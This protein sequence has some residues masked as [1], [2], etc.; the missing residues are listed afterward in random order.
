MPHQV[1]HISPAEDNTEYFPASPT[2]SHASSDALF[3]PAPRMPYQTTSP[4]GTL[5]LVENPSPTNTARVLAVD[6]AIG[7]TQPAIP[8]SPRAISAIVEGQAHALTAPVLLRMVCGLVLTTKHTED[9]MESV[10]IT[11]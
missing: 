11:A 9:R 10:R 7:A 2:E 4:T 5:P 1:I 8:L 6:L 3:I